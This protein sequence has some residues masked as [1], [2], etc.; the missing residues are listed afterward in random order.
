MAIAEPGEAFDKR[1]KK[2]KIACLKSSF[3]AFQKIWGKS[4]NFRAS[5]LFLSIL[6]CKAENAGGKIDFINTRSFLN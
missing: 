6:N 4:I 2:P 1:L 3:K 5:S